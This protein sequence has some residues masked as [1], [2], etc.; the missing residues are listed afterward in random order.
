MYTWSLQAP[1]TPPGLLRP[2][3]HVCQFDL[4]GLHLGD[5]RPECRPLC[6]VIDGDVDGRLR[7]AQ[8]LTRHA[9]ATSVWKAKERDLKIN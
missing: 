1:L 4:D 7:D 8:G 6:G 3:F 2:D 9:D 5:G